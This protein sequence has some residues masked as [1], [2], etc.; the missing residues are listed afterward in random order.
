MSDKE[1][2]AKLITSHTVSWDQACLIADSIL[3]AG[4]ASPDDLQRANEYGYDEGVSYSTDLASSHRK[5]HAD[6]RKF[7]LD[8]TRVTQLR[9][10]MDVGSGITYLDYDSWVA[11]HAIDAFQRE[12]DIND[13]NPFRPEKA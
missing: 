10:R 5:I 7:E 9:E 12:L 11:T 4:W 3:D 6:L 8:P 1:T 2:L 13:N